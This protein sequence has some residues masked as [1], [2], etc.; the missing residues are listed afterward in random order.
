MTSARSNPVVSS[1]RP[2]GVRWWIAAALVMADGAAGA[3]DFD[4]G[5]SAG[6]DTGRVDCVASAP[7][8]RGSAHF[9]ASAAYRLGDANDVQLTLF[10]AGQFTGG[11]TTPLGTEFGGRFKVSGVAL[12]AGYR[13]EIAPLWSLR[14]HAG[15]ASVRTSFEY[16]NPVWG[17]AGQSNVQ[18]LIGLGLAYA[19]TPT[20][21]LGLDGDMTRFKVHTTRGSVRMLGLA[22]QFSF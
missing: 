17:S 6:L 8:D 13:W 11:D 18:P 7:C 19:V 5:L 9:K 10:N 16:I 1:V 21:R 3:T 12:S 2:N 14:A 22:A 4:I 15:V 20:L